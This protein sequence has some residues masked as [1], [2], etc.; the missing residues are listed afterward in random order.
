[1]GC[2]S[3]YF[4]ASPLFKKNYIY[5]YYSA[6]DQAQFAKRS[7]TSDVIEHYMKTTEAKSN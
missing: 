5:I 6:K 2:E 7:G 1:M 4:P 3:W